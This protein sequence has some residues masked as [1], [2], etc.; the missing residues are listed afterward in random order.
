MLV[1]RKC[2]FVC[3]RRETRATLAH[4]KTSL[5][6]E[7]DA[8]STRLA[9]QVSCLPLALRKLALEW[10]AAGNFVLLAT[11]TTLYSGSTP[12]LSHG[13]PEPFTFEPESPPACCKKSHI[14]QSQN[15]VLG[16]SLHELVR[17]I[18]WNSPPCGVAHYPDEVRARVHY[19]SAALSSFQPN[20]DSS[21]CTHLPPVGAGILIRMTS[22][23]SDGSSGSWV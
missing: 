11:M 2:L 15:P 9:F 5:S 18:P 6:R 17:L 19:F 20:L 21:E 7:E 22:S 8:G 10:G 23:W 4:R 14:S 3:F 13:S 1:R 12:P 16:F